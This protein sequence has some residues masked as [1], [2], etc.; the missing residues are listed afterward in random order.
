MI[1]KEQSTQEKLSKL[2]FIHIKNFL[3]WNTQKLKRQSDRKHLQRDLYAEYI[4]NYQNSIRKQPNLKNGQK[5]QQ[6]LQT[7]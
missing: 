7:D 3:M 6:L 4:K 5:F 1:A 2:G